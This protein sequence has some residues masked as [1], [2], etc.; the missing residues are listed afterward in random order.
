MKAHQPKTAL[1]WADVERKSKQN[2]I[3]QADYEEWRANPVTMALYDEL[4][5]LTLLAQA[6]LGALVADCPN[7]VNAAQKQVLGLMTVVES[8]FE[9]APEGVKLEDDEDDS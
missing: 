7:K 9:W 1:F 5:K 2:P 4:E 8:V 3:S 6:E